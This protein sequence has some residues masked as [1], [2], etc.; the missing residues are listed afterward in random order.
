MKIFYGLI[1]GY[2]IQQFIIKIYKLYKNRELNRGLK[3]FNLGEYNNALK[4]F[5]K[6]IENNPKDAEGYFYGGLCLIYLGRPSESIE[7]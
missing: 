6:E 3:A 1:F 7:I 4:N 2:I 5:T